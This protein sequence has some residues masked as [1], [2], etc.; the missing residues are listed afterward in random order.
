MR[1]IELDTG[2]NAWTIEI[3][4]EL[5]HRIAA[6]LG[7]DAYAVVTDEEIKEYIL[8]HLMARHEVLSLEVVKG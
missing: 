1:I 8:E 6:T 7:R 3:Q 5:E 4:D 2:S